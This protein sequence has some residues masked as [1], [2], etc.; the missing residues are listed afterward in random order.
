MV[1]PHTTCKQVAVYFFCCPVA[2][3]AHKRDF[4]PRIIAMPPLNSAPWNC[5]ARVVRHEPSN[6]LSDT[7]SRTSKQ[8]SPPLSFSIRMRLKIYSLRFFLIPPLHHDPWRTRACA[9]SIERCLSCIIAP[10]R[11][12]PRD[13]RICLLY[14]KLCV[15]SLSLLSSAWFNE[16]P[17][18]AEA[19]EE[20]CWPSRAQAR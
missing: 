7:I 14:T 1:Y 10:R 8:G 12:L 6:I 16:I 17:I 15:P 11:S 2:F 4:L 20:A 13:F 19:S 18:K 3:I 5:L 9:W